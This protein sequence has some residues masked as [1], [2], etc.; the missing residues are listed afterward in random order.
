LVSE[1][2]LAGVAVALPPDSRGDDSAVALP[3]SD[4]SL[5]ICTFNLGLLA[6]LFVLTGMG[7]VGTEDWDWVRCGCVGGRIAPEEGPLVLGIE[8]ASDLASGFR[9][10]SLLGRSEEPNPKC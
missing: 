8:F 3:P 10:E 7:I 5:G 6:S 1:L 2:P 4:C 9:W